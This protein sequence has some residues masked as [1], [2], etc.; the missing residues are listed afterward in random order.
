MLVGQT[1]EVG[2]QVCWSVKWLGMLVS[3]TVGVGKE[4][5]W[6]GKQVW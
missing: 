1:G 2:M 4:V 3:Q 6:S 5:C